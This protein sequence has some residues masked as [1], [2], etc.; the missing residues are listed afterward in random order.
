[1]NPKTPFFFGRREYI[2]ERIP[3]API[4]DRFRYLDI[5]MHYR[6]LRNSDWKVEERFRKRLSGW[7]G[8]MFSI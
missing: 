2:I 3:L 7:K 5:P 8:K 1:L 4:N 6:K